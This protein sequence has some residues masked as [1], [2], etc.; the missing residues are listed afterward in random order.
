[1]KYDSWLDVYISDRSE[2]PAV[3]VAP[4]E[5]TIR[6]YK[7]EDDSFPTVTFYLKI[8]LKKKFHYLNAL[9]FKWR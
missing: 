1:M 6:F 3:V 5:E 8:I 9:L 7:S 2:I 4:G